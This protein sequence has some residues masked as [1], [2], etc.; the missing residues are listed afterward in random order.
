M[1]IEQEE[2]MQ[3]MIQADITMLEM[4]MNIEERL[5]KLEKKVNE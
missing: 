5:R 1:S 4:V 2:L 3:R